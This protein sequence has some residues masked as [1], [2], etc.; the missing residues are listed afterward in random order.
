[1]RGLPIVMLLVAGCGAPRARDTSKD[2]AQALAADEQRGTITII[3]KVRVRP[4]HEAAFLATAEQLIAAV[5]ANEPGVLLYA[6][7][8]SST[9]PSTYVWVERYRD[10]AAL[11]THLAS[12]HLA[13]VKAKV[14]AWLAGPPEVMKLEAVLPNGRDR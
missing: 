3:Y 5:R 7:T 6:L 10:A 2:E 11:A 4:E 14:P 1:M 12:P 13:E 8:R 9:E